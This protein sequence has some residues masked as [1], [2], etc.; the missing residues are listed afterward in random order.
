MSTRNYDGYYHAT[1]GRLRVRVNNLKN[2]QRTAK[3]LELLLLSQPGI[4]GVRASHITGNVLVK[5]EERIT[6]HETVL[7][8]LAD[9]G[10][11]PIVCENTQNTAIVDGSLCD[12]GIS[13]GKNL[14][15]VALKQ[16]L[17]GSPVAIILELL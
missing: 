8:S 6:S 7:Q 1:P 10:H 2:R 12:L 15:M 17:A 13:L 4:K 5:F 9:L 3:S 14:A 11:M 16:A